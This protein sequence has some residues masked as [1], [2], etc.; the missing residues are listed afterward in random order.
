MVD[1]PRAH[2]LAVWLRFRSQHG[3]KKGERAFPGYSRSNSRDVHLESQTDSLRLIVIAYNS[4]TH[5]ARRMAW[6]MCP[7][8]MAWPCGCGSAPGFAD[9][10]GVETG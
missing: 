7:V 6:W 4:P 1:V 8:L 2:G 9:H 10:L 5:V 3:A